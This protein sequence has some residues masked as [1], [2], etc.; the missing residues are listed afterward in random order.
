MCCLFVL[1]VVYNCKA[2]TFLTFWDLSK[3][4]QYIIF[5]F[6][7][8]LTALINLQSTRIGECILLL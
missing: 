1:K 5:I 7:I 8:M 6:S 4:L 3:Y 2:D